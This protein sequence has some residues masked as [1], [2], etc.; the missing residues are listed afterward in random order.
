MCEESERTRSLEGRSRGSSTRR[1]F[2]LG[3]VSGAL[4][5]GL[6]GA[7]SPA[8]RACAE[9]PPPTR[10]RV[11][12]RDEAALY[13][14]WCDV[15]APGAA[16]AGVSRYLDRQLAAPP[17]DTLLLLRVLANPPLDAFYRGGIAG[18]ERESAARF[19]ESFL[20]LSDPQ[21]R[22]VVDAAATTSTAAWKDPEP[23]FFYF[24]SRAD[25]VD[26]VWGTLR[27]FRELK[28][29]Y[30]AHIRPREPW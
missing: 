28:V 10:L 17:P 7:L 3:S 18:I 5:L 24:V 16:A 2:V 23:N 13:D 22:V 11:L 15:L 27:G 21:R 9:G 8:G 14:A 19:G 29:P 1:E 25:A 4:V 30:L 6:G 12:G 20:A 26:V